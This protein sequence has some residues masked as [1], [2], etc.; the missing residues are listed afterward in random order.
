MIKMEVLYPEY[1]NLYGDRGNIMYL[2]KI[3]PDLEI[4]YTGI[5]ETPL[6]TKEK[7]DILYLGPSTE[8]QQE[9]IAEKLK[10]FKEQLKK[11]IDDNVFILATGNAIEYFGQY[12]EKEK[13]NKIECLKIFDTYAKR[14]YR[15]RHNENVVQKVKNIILVGFKNQLSHSY[16]K[17]KFAIK[18]EKDETI[19][20]VIK[21]NF[22]G[23]YFLG[24]ILVL[25]PE[26]T[27]KI[28][29]DLNIKIDQKEYLEMAEK[30]NNKRIQE[31][32]I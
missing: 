23:T 10:P 27:T 21:N 9:A 30:A 4:T 28:F 14:I 22:F 15:L 3:I 24:P 18:S 25:N 6:F 2:Q 11:L 7:I 8:K 16:G 29:K 5:N 20:F 1:M 32:D 13:G 19:N 12:I 31:L 17:E 26:L